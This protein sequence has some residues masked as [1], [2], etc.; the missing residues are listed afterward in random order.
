MRTLNLGVLAHV[1]AGKTSLTER[2]LHAAGVIDELGSVDD[3]T[4]RTDSLELER[5]RGITIKSAVVSF[6]LGDDTVNLIDTPGHPDFIAEVERVLAVLDG[7]VLVVSAVAGVQA[8]TR[9]LMRALQRLRV[10]TVVF[11][12]KTD[13]AGARPRA[14]LEE[15]AAKLSPAVV[16]MAPFDAAA[17]AEVLAERD[18]ALLRAAVDGDAGPGR[19]RAALADQSRRA[20]A[21]PVFAGSAIT[22]AGVGALMDG[23]REFL[24]A[25]RGDA[26]GPVAG[27]V[28]KIE[29]G[30]AGERIAYVR[31]R[32]GT[33][34][35]RDRVALPGGE[36]KVTAVAVFEQGAAVSRRALE[37]G[38]IGKLWGLDDVRIGDAIG[39]PAGGAAAQFAPPTLET[40]VVPARE[41]DRGALHAALTQLAEQDPL[42]DLRRDELR[43]E[44]L[45]SLY[46][47]VQKEVVGAT[48]ADEYG[49]EVAFEASTTICI[50]RPAGTGAAVELIGV[51]PNPYLATVGLRVDPLPAGAGV[52]FALEVERGSMP[53]AFFTAVEESARET[54]AAGG[55]HGW[56]VPD[57][58]VTMTHSGYWARQSHSH[59]EFDK[60]MSST[61][62]D[63]RM[64]TAVVLARA[65]RNAGTEVLEPLHRFRLEAPPDVVGK[66]LAAL[67]GLRAVPSAPGPPGLLEGTI[68][69]ARVHEL[70]QRLPG[71]TRGEGY[72]ESVFERYEPVTGPVPRR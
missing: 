35:T 72:L 44:L 5:R 45:V 1:D 51:D 54:L 67:A 50:E 59:A 28:F 10:P 66:L 22:G 14:V 48:L 49:L 39:A 47:E 69:A 65:L 13:R 11:V 8:Q 7:A 52:T 18:E 12:N 57:C 29:R 19:V 15:I 16:G 9:V 33:L 70:Q 3:G 36:G 27:T 63:F 56:R 43:G 62:G 64:L 21:H 25:A 41:Q 46:G 6:A 40:V 26:G 71:L 30:G 55:N 53:P 31:L 2:L 24:P 58:A 61:A 20:L 23:L 17:A 32:S 4:T 34:R 42:I 37:A 68:P 38:R 60:S